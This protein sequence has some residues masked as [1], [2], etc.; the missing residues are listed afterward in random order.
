MCPVVSKLFICF[1]AGSLF[2]ED[3]IVQT[4]VSVELHTTFWEL[5]Q[6]LYQTLQ[7]FGN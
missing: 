3:L 1:C 4:F 7:R 2:G 6:F 5:I